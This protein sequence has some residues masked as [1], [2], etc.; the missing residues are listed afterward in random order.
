M[1]DPHHFYCSIKRQKSTHLC[2][3]CGECIVDMAL[4]VGQWD[5]RISWDDVE[6][7]PT[8]V[9]ETWCGKQYKIRNGSTYMG[10]KQLRSIVE[11]EVFN[12]HYRHRKIA[13]RVRKG[14]LKWKKQTTTPSQD[15][16]SP[17]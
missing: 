8:G 3:F 6:L 15:T 11:M 9:V 12:E 17:A 10:P 13:N 1:L 2:A 4:D 14:H 5:L 7:W 16:P